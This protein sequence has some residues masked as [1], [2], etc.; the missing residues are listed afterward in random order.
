[1][2][3]QVMN[4]LEGFIFDLKAPK[5]K[6]NIKE[7]DDQYEFKALI[8]G[9]NKDNIKINYSNDQLSIEIIEVEEDFDLSYIK[10]EIKTN[11]Q[12]RSFLIPNID[13]EKSSATY[14]DGILT[15]VLPKIKN[16]ENLIKIKDS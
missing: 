10:K 8:G 9:V 12:K 3:N 2:I 1:M 11:Y 16:E 14:N 5:M 6:V 4:D 7:H 15:I 13:Y